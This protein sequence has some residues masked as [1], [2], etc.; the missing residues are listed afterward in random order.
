[1]ASR[2]ADKIKE[3]GFVPV[4]LVDGEVE[5]FFA[6]L[7]KYIHLIFSNILVANAFI[8]SFVCCRH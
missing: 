6:A 5:W 7:G 4:D 1:M 8:H 2:V 3:S